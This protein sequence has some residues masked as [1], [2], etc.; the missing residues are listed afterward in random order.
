MPEASKIT[1]IGET[2]LI[3]QAINL[4]G[5]VDPGVGSGPATA[6]NVDRTSVTIQLKHIT[7][8]SVDSVMP[9]LLT[10]RQIQVVKYAPFGNGAG[11]VITGPGSDVDAFVQ[12]IKGLDVSTDADR[13]VRLVRI[14]ADDPSSVLAAAQDLYTKTGKGERDPVSASYD[15]E[16]RTATLIGSR[17]GLAAFDQLLSTAQ[18]AATVEQE[19]RKFALKK[20]EATVLAQKLARLSRPLLM[21]T[22][23]RP[24]TEPTF[25]GIDEARTIIVKARPDQFATIAGLIEQLDVE[26]AAARELKVVK[27]AVS[28][29]SALLERAKAL[30]DERVKGM[31]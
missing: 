11:L 24:Y 7:P 28:D 1:L 17:A 20:A 30:Y 25:E 21:P 22:D 4:L 5:E 8:Q 6:P 12:L 16:S 27:L 3:A 18:N 14:K 10:P 2:T 15:P 13:E 26:E 19:A 9:R 31:G 23:G 29:P